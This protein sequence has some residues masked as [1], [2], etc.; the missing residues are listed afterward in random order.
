MIQKD[1]EIGIWTLRIYH[2]GYHYYI[3]EE[4]R[5]YQKSSVPVLKNGARCRSH[6]RWLNRGAV[7]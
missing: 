4:R 2:V 1:L 3:K 6:N 5:F 7:L